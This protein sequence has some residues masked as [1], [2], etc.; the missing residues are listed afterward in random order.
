[1]R[2]IG[3]VELGIEAREPQHAADCEGQ[4]RDPAEAWQFLEGPQ[5]DN[6]RRRNTE[7]DRIGQTVQ[8]RPELALRIEQPRRAAINPVEYAGKDHRQHRLLE[9]AG[10][11]KANAGKPDAERRGGDRT[12][13][14]GPERKPL[15][16]TLAEAAAAH[17]LTPSITSS[18]PS[19]A[20]TVS[21]AMIFW[22]SNTRD[23]EPAGK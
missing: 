1:M 16:E 22:P 10:N 7:R 23:E 20:S 6:Q 14:K 5:I 18:L 12:W 9:F 15:S 3:Q 8:L 2:H 4:R 21:P 13:N 19:S 17:W 11:R